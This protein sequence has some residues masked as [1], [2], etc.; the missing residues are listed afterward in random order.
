MKHRLRNSI[1]AAAG[2]VSVVLAGGG[3]ASAATV[4]VS[5]PQI[6]AH[7]DITKGQTVEAF[8][9]EPSGAADLS[10]SGTPSR[11]DLSETCR[12]VPRSGVG[13]S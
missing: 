11:H 7:L 3:T 4:R 10:L 5:D 2:S 9:V 12:T 6:F 1:V 13:P 8:A